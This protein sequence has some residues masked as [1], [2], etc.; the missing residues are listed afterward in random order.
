[1][2]D[3]LKTKPE[4]LAEL[5][6][7][8]QRLAELEPPEADLTR[9]RKTVLESEEHYRAAVD[10]IADAIV[11]NVG[12]IRVFVN[13][14]FLALHGLEDMSQASG[15]ALDHFIVP[16][17]KPLVRE[18]TLARERG[19]PVP[20]VYEYRIG[21]SNGEDRTVEASAVAITF[22]G[23][24]ATLA[25][26]RDVTERK[27]AEA[28]LQ[29]SEERVRRLAEIGRIISSTLNV[30]E[31][32][33]PFAE[34][35]RE[36][37]PCE[38]IVITIAEPEQGVF[39]TAYVRGG[40]VAARR[41]GDVT[42]LA[43]SLTE[44]VIRTRSGL[45]FQPGNIEDLRQR[46]TGPLPAFEAGFRSFLSVPLISHDQVIGV[47][48]LEASKPEAYT[49][50]DLNFAESVGAQIS[51]AIANA[52]L[53]EQL[54]TERE[55]LRWL[56]MRVVAEEE[57]ERHRVSR[58][59]HDEAGQA[60]TALKISLGL[61]H[62]DMPLESGTLSARIADAVDLTDATME[63]IRLLAR[64]LR[65]PELDAVGLHGTLEGYCHEF[66]GRTNLSIDYAGMEMSTLTDAVNISFYRFLQEALTNVAK[67]AG[68]NRIRVKLS[69][70][71]GTVSLSVVD[72]GRGFVPR[73]KT[74]DP[75]ESGGIG[76]LGMHERFELLG[77]RLEVKS[78]PGQGTRL[79]AHVP[80][81]EP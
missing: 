52:Q 14:A 4:L 58:E 69:R 9:G 45:L 68:A 51:G 40:D 30:E 42:A 11:I 71:S 5:E 39:T 24:P 78:R 72:D 6:G 17:D 8:R 41:P 46:F 50:R 21:R 77:G 65:P 66:A 22:N 33:E 38:R 75:G 36:L 48:H 31:V 73:S 74:A 54:E 43:S 35:V 18:R 49:E 76:L 20:G 19:E 64:G 16:E 55:R 57:E 62:A 56:T 13:N 81:K 32:Y 26:L 1:M 59:L 7:L 12:T 10:N 61:I 53:F 15:L 67:H 25:V 34:Q 29:E 28:A 70:A 60:L 44:E 2:N 27:Q 3:E 47:L 80:V 37:I 63:E 23:Q 79:V